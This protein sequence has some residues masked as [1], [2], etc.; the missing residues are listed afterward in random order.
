MGIQAIE[1]TRNVLD[2]D[3]T[4]KISCYF[5]QQADNGAAW[6]TIGLHIFNP[7]D[8]RSREDRI[9][10]ATFRILGSSLLLYFLALTDVNYSGGEGQSMYQWYDHPS[11]AARAIQLTLLPMVQIPDYN[12]NSM[13][14]EIVKHATLTAR[15]ELLK[16]ASVLKYFRPYNWLNKESLSGLHDENMELTEQQKI[17]VKQVLAKYAF[18]N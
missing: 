15:T 2:G 16:M 14:L 18:T 11:S 3:M 13:D 8:L 1:E 12:N 7:N 17:E 9:S 4:R 10:D 5:E 6:N